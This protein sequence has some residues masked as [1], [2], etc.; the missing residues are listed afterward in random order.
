M[1]PKNVIDQLSDLN[2]EA[3]LFDNMDVAIVGIG[4]IGHKDPVAVYSKAK[5]YNKLLG[6]GLSIEDAEEYFSAKFTGT[7]AGENTPLILDDTTEQ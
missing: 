6:D 3:Y 1:G 5:I 4:Y 2:P 7:W